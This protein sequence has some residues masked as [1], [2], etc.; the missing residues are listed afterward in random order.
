[1]RKTIFAAVLAA[2]L[3]IPAAALAEEETAV[4]E[5]VIYEEDGRKVTVTGYGEGLMG[6]EIEVQIENN[7][8]EAFTLQI[9][10]SSVNG[11]MTDLEASI[12]VEPG[13]IS[14][15]EVTIPASSLEENGIEQVAD[16]ELCLHFF[17]PDSFGTIADSEP[18]SIET[19]LSGT[20][21]QIL[22]DSG[23]EVYNDRDVRIVYQGLNEETLWGAEPMFYIENNR[24]Q[25]IAVQLRD[26]SVNGLMMDPSFSAEIA[27]GKVYIGGA[28]F[29]S[30]EMEEKGITQITEM[31]T[32]F[33]IFDP[34][35]YETI[36]DSDIAAI[37][38]GEGGEAASREEVSGEVV[39]DQDGIR[40]VSQ[41]LKED[42]FWGAELLFYIE[43][44]TEQKI[45]V[46]MEGTYINGVL[47]HPAFA[48]EVMP[49][50][51]SAESAVLFSAD[52]EETGEVKELET[53]F[54]IYDEDTH[55]TIA[56]TDP[57]LISYQ[58]PEEEDAEW[59]WMT[60]AGQD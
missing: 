56:D 60:G 46:E 54:H 38:T 25:K 59:E 39:Y 11:I 47:V 50:K 27:P 14:K 28:V 30:S 40:I 57:V 24:E 58:I 5:Q 45:C 44:N 53:S 29:F 22:D 35:T 15:E 13:K 31:E 36:A 3:S 33:H 17:D 9:R 51:S 41:G 7:S 21:R 43:N 34:D 12:E 10:D 19:N 49:G 16:I 52:V 4:D 48:E 6:P 42:T 26:T 32:R 8:D 18:I 1:M 20:Y 37:Q 55:E 2:L 23:E